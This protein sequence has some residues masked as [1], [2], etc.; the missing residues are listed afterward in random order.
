LHA[1]AKAPLT[2]AN[3]SPGFFFHFATQQSARGISQIWL[4]LPLID[5]QFGYISKLEEKKKK[6]SG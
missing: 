5:D 6:P 4:D 2:K 1:A 3:C